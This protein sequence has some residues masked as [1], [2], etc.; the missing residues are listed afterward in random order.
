[1][2]PNNVARHNRK[3]KTK[4][5]QN[6]LMGNVARHRSN[7]MAA[8]QLQENVTRLSSN[9]QQNGG[10]T[11]CQEMLRSI[12]ARTKQKGAAEHVSWKC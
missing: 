12:V 11:T 6:V 10:K 9:E 3:D 1:M 8:N 2:W 7:K 4:W 5:R